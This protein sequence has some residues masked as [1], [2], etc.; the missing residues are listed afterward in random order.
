LNTLAAAVRFRMARKL[1]AKGNE[2][3]PFAWRAILCERQ[4]DTAA[5]STR[6]SARR[7]SRI[8]VSCAIVRAREQL[9]ALRIGGPAAAGVWDS[10]HLDTAVTLPV[11]VE[12]YAAHALGAWLSA[13]PA[14]SAGTRRFARWSATGSLVLGMAGQVAWHLLAQEH[15]A[16]APWAVTTGVSCLSVLVGPG[17]VTVSQ[18]PSGQSRAPRNSSRLE[19]AGVQRQ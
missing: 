17:A 2:R 8:A 10:L 5:A 9:L 1:L 16:R 14:V 4:D 12:A 6:P 15:A 19:G 18:T 7:L 3:L 13:S 11:G